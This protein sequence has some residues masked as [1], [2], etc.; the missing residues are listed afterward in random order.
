VE[1]GLEIP[2]WVDEPQ[3]FPPEMWD[4]AEDFFPYPDMKP[5][6]QERLRPQYFRDASGR[7][8]SGV[9]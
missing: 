2:A 7:E 5:Y 6:R 9:T 3:Y 4:A 1:F 8:Q